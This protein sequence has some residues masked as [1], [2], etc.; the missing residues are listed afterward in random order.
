[1]TLG[2]RTLSSSL[3][4]ESGIQWHQVKKLVLL[5]TLLA[6]NGQKAESNFLYMLLLT[7]GMTASH[8]TAQLRGEVEF[9]YSI[10]LTVLIVC[11]H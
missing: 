8:T 7:D 11:S 10:H 6:S 1:L 5:P 9:L 4:L 3:R 2:V